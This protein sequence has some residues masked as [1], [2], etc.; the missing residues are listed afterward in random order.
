MYYLNKGTPWMLQVLSSLL[1]LAGEDLLWQLIIPTLALILFHVVERQHY[2]WAFHALPMLHLSCSQ[3]T[4][5]PASW[6]QLHI[7]LLLSLG[8]SEETFL[9]LVQTTFV[10]HFPL[11]M[12]AVLPHMHSEVKSVALGVVGDKDPLF[13]FSGCVGLGPQG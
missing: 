10:S 9:W 5:H 13:G 4:K 12:M 8:A 1:L 11:V 2:V 7:N 6:F 3:P